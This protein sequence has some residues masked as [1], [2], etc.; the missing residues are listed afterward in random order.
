MN[1]LVLSLQDTKLSGVGILS[2]TDFQA[3]QKRLAHTLLWNTGPNS[4][5]NRHPRSPSQ[6]GA[7]TAALVQAMAAAPPRA[8]TKVGTSTAD[9]RRMRLPDEVFAYASDYQAANRSGVMDSRHE[10]ALLR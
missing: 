3:S 4:V 1:K 8:I 6:S 9:D 5:Q 7:D 10:D 2:L